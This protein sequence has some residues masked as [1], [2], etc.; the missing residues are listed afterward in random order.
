MALPPSITPTAGKKVLAQLKKGK[1][2]AEIASAKQESRK[3]S[4]GRKRTA[5]T[6]KRAKKLLAKDN[7]TCQN[8]QRQM[9]AKLGVS[10]STV[11]R[12]LKDVG[13]RPLKHVR[14]VHNTE[15]KRAKRVRI[16][17]DILAAHTA[18]MKTR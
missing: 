2:V 14:V 4:T 17:N 7:S 3:W 9:A 13:V 6:A 16:A 1:T 8:S 12:V 15:T 5:A 18:G 11:S 10:H